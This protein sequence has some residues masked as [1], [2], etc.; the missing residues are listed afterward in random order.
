MK[1]VRVRFFEKQISIKAPNIC[2]F[3][4]IANEP[5]FISEEPTTTSH[6][7]DSNISVWRCGN[8]DCNNVIV[9]LYKASDGKTGAYFK[10]FLDGSQKGPNW[11]KPILELKNGRTIRATTKSS[12]DPEP[13]C[14]F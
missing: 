14:T 13:V 1:Q 2:P 4:H 11:P 6:V 5:R 12:F 10:R 7:F 3:C 8:D 9:A